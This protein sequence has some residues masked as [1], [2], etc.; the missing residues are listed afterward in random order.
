[1]GGPRFHFAVFATELQLN[2]LEK[3][4]RP[5]ACSTLWFATSSFTYSL[6]G[7]FVLLRLDLLQA[8][9]GISPY[10]CVWR[11]EGIASYWSDAWNFGLSLAAARMDQA[12]ATSLFCMQLVK[13]WFLP[14]DGAQHSSAFI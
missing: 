6:I 9:S 11:S 3:V 10:R 12:L 8:A 13:S 2:A 4:Y 7:A 14:M 1:M 5:V